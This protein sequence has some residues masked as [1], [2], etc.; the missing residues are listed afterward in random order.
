MQKQFKNLNNNLQQQLQYE[1]KTV[2]FR[3]EF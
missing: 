2:Y 3:E 1:G